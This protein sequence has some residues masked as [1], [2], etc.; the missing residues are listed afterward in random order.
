MKYGHPFLF[1]NCKILFT[2]NTITISERQVVE[3][4]ETRIQHHSATTSVQESQKHQK[5]NLLKD[6]QHG[7]KTTEPKNP[8]D[9]NN[10]AH[11]NKNTKPKQNNKS[12][13]PHCIPIYP[14]HHGYLIKKF[15]TEM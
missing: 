1:L 8:S 2:R 3:A 11:P 9:Q 13:M 7:S 5:L 12:A 15:M 6:V 4:N 10:N 14:T